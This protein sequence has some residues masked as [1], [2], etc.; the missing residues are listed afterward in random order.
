MNK[1]MSALHTVQEK[2]AE[3]AEAA[4]EV[5][6]EEAVGVEPEDHVCEE[7]TLSAAGDESDGLDESSLDSEDG[8][9]VDSEVDRYEAQVVYET[10]SSSDED[11]LP[12][13]IESAGIRKRRIEIEECSDDELYGD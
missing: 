1:L 12:N 8:S 5:L 9:E 3:V 6:E 2:T 13:D 11:S 4:T 7:E 10:I